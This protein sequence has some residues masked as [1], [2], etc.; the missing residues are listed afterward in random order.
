MIRDSK[1]RK[2]SFGTYDITSDSLN[3][4]TSIAGSETRFVPLR[5]GIRP[6]T[7]T[8]MAAK[9]VLEN[10][11]YALWRKK[12]GWVSL[13][14][15]EGANPYH[16]RWLHCR[17]FFLFPLQYF[18]PTRPPPRPASLGSLLD[19]R[20]QGSLCEKSR[21]QGRTWPYSDL[22]T[23]NEDSRCKAK[24]RI[25]RWWFMAL[26]FISSYPAVLPV[27]C[28]TVTLRSMFRSD[29]VGTRKTRL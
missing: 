23:W 12:S 21:E 3:A 20:S 13:N 22:E 28:Y 17:S 8:T 25:I 16:I 10:W 27:I 4:R 2:A 18:C 19:T 1:K 26:R 7:L 29:A 15:V 9:R 11:N 6:N 14:S 24:A 5:G